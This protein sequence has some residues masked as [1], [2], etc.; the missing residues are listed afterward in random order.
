MRP[1]SQFMEL[2]QSSAHTRCVLRQEASQYPTADAD[3]FIPSN[4]GNSVQ[5]R[6]PGG[7]G[8]LTMK[9]EFLGVA[10]RVH[11]LGIRRDIP[12]LM[13]ASVATLLP[14]ER[15]GLPRSIMESLALA[16]PVI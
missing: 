10:D 1:G 2:A 12:N 7:S 5:L 9:A 3:Q 4:Q 13:R 16:V 8:T 14:S 15:E 11:F 6:A